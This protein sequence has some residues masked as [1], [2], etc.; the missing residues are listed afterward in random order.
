MKKLT[1]SIDS[2]N[3]ELHGVFQPSE[4][5]NYYASPDGNE[6]IEIPQY[7]SY[8]EISTQTEGAWYSFGSSDVT[9]PAPTDTVTDGSAPNY[10][11]PNN[12]KI[13]RILSETH[14]AIDSEGPV[15]VSYW[16]Q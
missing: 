9:A 6:S 1:T 4:F 14:L 10:L 16:S 15:V 7:A 3:R 2:R 8:L 11:I 12:R 13:H 5:V